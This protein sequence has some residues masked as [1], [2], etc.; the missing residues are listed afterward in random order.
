M[1]WHGCQLL[2]PVHQENFMSI[3]FQKL[4]PEE[5]KAI[6]DS[7]DPELRITMKSKQAAEFLKVSLL[8]IYDWVCSGKLEGTYRKRGK[9][10]IFLTSRLIEKFFNGKDWGFKS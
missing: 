4:S 10:L 7:L 2:H 6:V 9:Y 1:S 8:T 3:Q 5:L